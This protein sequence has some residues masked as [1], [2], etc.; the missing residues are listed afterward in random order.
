M[1]VCVCVCAYTNTARGHTIRYERTHALNTFSIPG[2]ENKTNSAK[3]KKTNQYE[4]KKQIVI[5]SA[6]FDKLEQT[7][8]ELRAQLEERDGE[9]LEISDRSHQVRARARTHTH[10]HTHTQGGGERETERV[11]A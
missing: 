2:A 9:V 3:K 6:A 7:T 4:E 5:L 10:T 11:G 1:C 8:H